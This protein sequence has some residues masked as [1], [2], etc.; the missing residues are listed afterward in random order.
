LLDGDPQVVVEV[1]DNP[2][3]DLAP[4]VGCAY[5][6]KGTATT[7]I[8]G[9]YG[10]FWDAIR[11]IS[12][13]RFLTDQPFSLDYLVNGVTFSNPYKSFS[14]F[15]WSM[16]TTPEERK[17]YPFVTPAAAAVFN[18]DFRTP[19]TQQWNFNIQRRLPWHT[20]VTTAYVGS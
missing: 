20:V 10:F 6:V 15:P 4:R 14:P 16:P 18:P 8:R 7:V 19:Y 1:I 9:G 13:N 12:M 11:T 17:A 5:D 3:R 2:W